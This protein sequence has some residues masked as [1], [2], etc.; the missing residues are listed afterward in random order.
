MILKSHNEQVMAWTSL[1]RPPASPPANIRQSNNQFFAS[2]NL[3]KNEDYYR[4]NTCF[5]RHEQI[6][7]APA[8]DHVRENVYFRYYCINKS[9]IP[10]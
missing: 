2:E 10:K 6:V 3:V 5:R 9:H 4:D 8:D 1:F 7:R